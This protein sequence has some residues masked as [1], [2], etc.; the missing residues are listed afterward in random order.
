ME[1]HNALMPNP[2]VAM[3]F[4][5]SADPTP[6]VMLNLLRFRPRAVYADGRQ[7]DLTGEEAF[8]IYSAAMNKIVTGFGGRFIVSALVDEL[9][10]GSGELVWHRVA[11]IE[12][13]SKQ[14]FIAVASSPEV[15]EAAVHRHAGLEGQLLISTRLQSLLGKPVGA[16]ERASA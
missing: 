4:R 1:L 2:D 16:G 13:P 3:R 11:M 12:Y 9:V 8:M 10:I 5:S 14:A 6:V 15:K 7:S